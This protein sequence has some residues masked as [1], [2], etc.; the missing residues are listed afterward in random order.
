M[1]FPEGLS[2]EGWKPKQRI[3]RKIRAVTIKS[4]PR[5]L[6]TTHQLWRYCHGVNIAHLEKDMALTR[7]LDYR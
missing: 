6:A 5:K 4:N 7:A 3:D 1:A 2:S